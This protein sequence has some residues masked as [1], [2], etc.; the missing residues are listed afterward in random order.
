MT[1]LQKQLAKLQLDDVKEE[2]TLLTFK[3]HKNQWLLSAQQSILNHVLKN[4]EE[5]LRVCEDKDH[6]DIFKMKTSYATF[7]EFKQLTALAKKVLK[8]RKFKVC[9]RT[10]DTYTDS[11]CQRC[12]FLRISGW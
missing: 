12:Y 3:A 2:I 11:T 5:A 4:L 6:Y 8:S 9:Y 10:E 1:D 7:S